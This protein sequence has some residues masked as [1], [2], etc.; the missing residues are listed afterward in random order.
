M[1]SAPTPLVRIS[2]FRVRLRPQSVQRID[3]R[4]ARQVELLLVDPVVPEVEAGEAHG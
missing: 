4:S 2:S 3:S 1:H